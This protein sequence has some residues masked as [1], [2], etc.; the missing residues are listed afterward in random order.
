MAVLAS[1]PVPALLS[2]SPPWLEDAAFPPPPEPDTYGYLQG[3]HSQ[4]CSQPELID[5]IQRDT[6]KAIAL[7]WAPDTPRA[8]PPEALPWLFEALRDRERAYL[9][10]AIRLALINT[11]LF[12][13]T[14]AMSAATRRGAGQF[15]VFLLV[16][17]GVIP[18]LKQSW[19]LYRLPGFTPE[20]LA[21]RLPEARYASWLGR[22]RAPWSWALL[23]CISAVA[24]VQFLLGVRF[25]LDPAHSTIAAAGIVKPAIRAGEWWRLLTGTLLHGNVMHFV[26]NIIALFVLSKIVEVTFHRAYVPIV[27]VLAA[28]GGSLASLALLPD[29]TSVGASGGIMGLLGFV[30]VLAWAQRRSFPRSL[31]RS[32]L[33]SVVYIVLAG[34]LA[35]QAIDNPAHLGGFGTG[36]ALGLIRLRSHPVQMPDR[37]S[38]VLMISA[39]LASGIILATAAGCLLLMLWR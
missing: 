8:Q 20:A 19:G 39:Y 37:V 29:T 3:K 11:V 26:F 23:W 25:L 17:L 18:L 14:L 5:Q 15:Q 27:F 32:L 35:S 2:A 9:K 6:N 1:E 30:L 4:S 13:L 34:L 24:L 12:A 33:I 31:Q 38:P 10:Q 16:T 28:L 36:M 21:R 22:M 7:V